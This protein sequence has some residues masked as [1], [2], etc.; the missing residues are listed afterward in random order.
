[1]REAFAQELRYAVE[2]LRALDGKFA[3]ADATVFSGD[4]RRLL[5][6]VDELHRRAAELDALDRPAGLIEQAPPPTEPHLACPDEPV[7][8]TPPTSP[9]NGTEG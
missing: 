1:M 3:D 8:E 9:P 6:A 2:R 5:H 4:T 7:V